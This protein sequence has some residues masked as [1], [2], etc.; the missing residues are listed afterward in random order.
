MTGAANSKRRTGNDR[1][2]IHIF[3]I[4]RVFDV[5]GEDMGRL[6]FDMGRSTYKIPLVKTPGIES[7]FSWVRPDPAYI[8]LHTVLWTTYKCEIKWRRIWAD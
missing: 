4:F 2:R 8:D 5:L 7:V 1:L 6:I 3:S